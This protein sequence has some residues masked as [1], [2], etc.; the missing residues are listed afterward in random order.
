M[1]ISQ[2]LCM[3]PFALTLWYHDRGR[4]KSFSFSDHFGDLIYLVIEFASVTSHL[5]TLSYKT[6]QT[7]FRAS[8]HAN[9][10]YPASLT[11]RTLWILLIVC[12]LIQIIPPNITNPCLSPP[13]NSRPGLQ[14]VRR[15]WG[16]PERETQAAPHKDHLHVGAAQGAGAGVPGGCW[17]GV[18]M[19][20]LKD[21]RWTFWTR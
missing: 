14:D 21:L 2:I 17:G 20:P 12:N 10:T 7:I 15:A 6:S 18:R 16:G 11:Y 3:I 19:R 13:H 8:F 1:L 9:H 5:Q 4:K